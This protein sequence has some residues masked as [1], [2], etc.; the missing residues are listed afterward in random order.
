MYLQNGFN[1]LSLFYFLL[2]QYFLQKFVKLYDSWTCFSAVEAKR[3]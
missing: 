3:H 2:L 1:V